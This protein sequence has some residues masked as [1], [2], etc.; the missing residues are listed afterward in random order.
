MSSKESTDRESPRTY[1]SVKNMKA[2]NSRG[3]IHVTCVKAPLAWTGN[4]QES[5]D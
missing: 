4:T 3:E 2:H 5:Q 1:P